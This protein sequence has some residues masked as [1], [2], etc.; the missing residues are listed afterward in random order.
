MQRIRNFSSVDAE[1][2]LVGLDSQIVAHQ[3]ALVLPM[4]AIHFFAVRHP[5]LPHVDKHHEVAV[6]PFHHVRRKRRIR[7][8]RCYWKNSWLANVAENP[9]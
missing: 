4:T 1:S 9:Y 3:I 8:N 2:H 5:N 6:A 7:P